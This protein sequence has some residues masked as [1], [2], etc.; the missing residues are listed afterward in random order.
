MIQAMEGGRRGGDLFERGGR[1]SGG[2]YG[3]SAGWWRRVRRAAAGNAQSHVR[4]L[5]QGMRGTI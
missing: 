5:W 1:G 2:S 4:R 3:I